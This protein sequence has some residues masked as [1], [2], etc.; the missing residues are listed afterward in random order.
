MSQ[1]SRRAK[2]RGQAKQPPVEPPAP[3]RYQKYLPAWMKDGSAPARPSRPRRARPQRP[4]GG[5]TPGKFA[6]GDGIQ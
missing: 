5:Y 4:V 3:D 1:R 6:L 2:R